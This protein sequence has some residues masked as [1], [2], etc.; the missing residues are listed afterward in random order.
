[1]KII[2]PEVTNATAICD[3]VRRSIIHL[4]WKDHLDD[5]EVLGRWLEGKTPERIRSWLENPMNR[6]LIAVDQTRVLGAGCVT[7][8]GEITLNYVAPEARFAGVSRTLLEELECLAHAEGHSVV[9]LDS[10]TTARRF[11]LER[12]YRPRND[13]TTKYGLPTWPM[14][15]TL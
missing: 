8:G 6:M 7:S 5:P 9:V 4:C 2:R 11:Y 15:K 13:E 14:I 10:T 12:G 1:M 3:I